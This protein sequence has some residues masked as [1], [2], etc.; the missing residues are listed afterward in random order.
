M[1]HR[2]FLVVGRRRHPRHRRAVQITR[3][4]QQPGRDLARC[5]HTT[6]ITPLEA[7][8]SMGTVTDPALCWRC[9]QREHSCAWN[10]VASPVVL[11]CCVSVAHLCARRVRVVATLLHHQSPPVV[12]S[13]SS[14]SLSLLQRSVVLCAL[15]SPLVGFVRS[16][17]DFPTSARTPLRPMPLRQ[18]LVFRPRLLRPAGNQ[19]AFNRRGPALRGCALC[20]LPLCSTYPP[21]SHSCQKKCISEKNTQTQNRNKTKTKHTPL[22]GVRGLVRAA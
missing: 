13:S 15:L 2:R 7:T 4:A 18:L 11:T 9:D 19:L 8:R 17:D 16:S 22:V 3:D 5:H 21:P 12:A 10:E 6:T 14:V 20:P 1:R